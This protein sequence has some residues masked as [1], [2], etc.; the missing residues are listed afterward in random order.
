[1]KITVPKI[2]QGLR[3][4]EYAEEFGDLT[5]YVWVNP[6]RSL[7]E[8]MFEKMERK[9]EETDEDYAVKAGR[10]IEIFAELWSQCSDPETHWTKDELVQLGMET[11]ETDP[12]LWPWLRNRTL[13]MISEH[14]RLEKKR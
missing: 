6:P 9:P 2:V 12:A 13:E 3:V 7:L 1:M 4:R 11:M 5:I 8:E 14:R 10:V